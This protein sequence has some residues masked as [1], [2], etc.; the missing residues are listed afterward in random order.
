MGETSV[1]K[2]SK[3]RPLEMIEIEYRNLDDTLCSN[4][5]HIRFRKGVQNGACVTRYDQLAL[6]WCPLM[7]SSLHSTMKGFIVMWL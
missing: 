2:Y 1:V 4:Q 3:T 6:H 5:D 7:C